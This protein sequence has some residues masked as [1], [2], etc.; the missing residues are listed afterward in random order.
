MGGGGVGGAP[1]RAWKEIIHTQAA[2]ATQVQKAQDSNSG[3][4]GPA[5]ILVVFIEFWQLS[6]V[7]GGRRRGLWWLLPL[8][9]NSS[10]RGGGGGGGWSGGGGG[11]F[12][13]GGFSGG[14]GSG[15]G[16]GASGS[17]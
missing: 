4:I 10:S 17:W 8:I 12:G 2:A 6:G 7:L 1:L 11:G 16:G 15:G 5:T 3:E 13:G 14:G 9:L